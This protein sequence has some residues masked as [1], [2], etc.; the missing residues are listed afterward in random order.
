MNP[1]IV[2][3]NG[4]ASFDPDG[5]IQSYLWTGPGTISNANA[6][7]IQ[8]SNCSLG[9]NMFILKVTD[10]HGAIDM[11]TVIVKIGGINRTSV[12]VQLVPFDGLSIPRGEIVSAGS[13]NKILFAGGW[14]GL[15]YSTGSAFTTRVDIYDIS[16][17][18]WSTAELSQPRVEIGVAVAGDKI[19]FAGGT[20]PIPWG[21][22]WGDAG[23]RS[24]RIDIYDVSNNTWSTS[25]LSVARGGVMAAS[26][27][28][29]VLFAGG[30]THFDD[31]SAV[32]DIFNLESNSWTTTSLT[33]RRFGG[34][35]TV[36]DNKIYF[37]G[38]L[39]T[40]LN[41]VFEI[42]SRID[43]YD[44]SSNIWSISELNQ[45]RLGLAGIAAGSKNYWAGGDDNTVEIRD[46]NAQTSSLF[47]LFQPN[48][49]FDAVK[50]NNRVIFFTGR[51]EIRNKFDIYD[52]TN[53]SWTIGV[54]NQVV[55]GAAIIS[56]NN[57]VYV[58]GG[59]VNGALSRQVWKLE[60]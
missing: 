15:P 39:Y 45:A 41:D 11:D 9:I 12:A 38:G 22:A 34:A 20:I 60:L 7:V 24:S 21:G 51:G 13:G 8:I 56:F 30:H 50:K 18:T 54:L 3:L 40:I 32:V 37:A 31:A 46:E 19:F 25:E 44:A 2:T 47:C 26:A 16:T 23:Y 27:G 59:Y 33:Q 36:I 53:A 28:N 6:A 49:W 58:A 17:N 10:N 29:R 5:T 4:S 42:T 57:T 35:A 48:S 55:F 43:I 52:F 1:E 14:T